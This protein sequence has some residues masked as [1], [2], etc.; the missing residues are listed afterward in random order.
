MVLAPGTSGTEALQAAVPE[1]VPLCPPL[2]FVQ[3]TEEMGP[4]LEDALPA[5]PTG[6]TF[7]P[8]DGGPAI[9]IEIPGARKEEWFTKLALEAF[10]A[11]AFPRAPTMTTQD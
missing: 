11:A 7:V 5:I 10:P 8:I 3:V 9:A 6:A 1:A 4:S 2:R